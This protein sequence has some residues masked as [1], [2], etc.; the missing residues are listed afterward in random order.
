MK[1]IAS[2]TR[3]VEEI[4][5]TT[6]EFSLHVSYLS[7]NQTE[8]AFNAAFCVKYRHSKR[9]LYISYSINTN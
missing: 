2:P 3:S 5:T 1:A 8:T 7:N 9:N 4:D 6:M